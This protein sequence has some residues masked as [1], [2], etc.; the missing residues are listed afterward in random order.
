MITFKCS[1]MLLEVD[2]LY[3]WGRG[4]YGQLG[5]SRSD[6]RSFSPNPGKI[7][8]KVKMKTFECGS[9]HTL[10]ISGRDC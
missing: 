10:F 2:D 4:D 7:D 6:D 1:F 9:E 3:S 5:R 8:T